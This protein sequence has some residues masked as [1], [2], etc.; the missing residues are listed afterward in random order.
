MKNL[1][2]TNKE[3]IDKIKKEEKIYHENEWSGR[4][5]PSFDISHLV[6]TCE[7]SDIVNDVENAS[8][9]NDDERNNTDIVSL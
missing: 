2:A 7:T 8:S 9:S 5:T 4:P 3:L 1:K 6:L